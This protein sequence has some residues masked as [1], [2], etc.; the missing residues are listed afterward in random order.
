M[1]AIRNTIVFHSLFYS[2]LNLATVVYMTSFDFLLLTVYFLCVTS[3]LTRVINSFNDEFFIIV[4]QDELK[5]QLEGVKLDDRVD[6]SF[7]FK[8]RY[9]FHTLKEFGI[10]VK[11]KSPDHP[12]YVDWN[13]SSVTD[14]DGKARRVTRLIP[15]NSIDLFQ[16]QALSPVAANNTLKENIVAEDMLKRKGDDGPLEIEKPLLDLS[17]PKKPGDALNRYFE[18]MSLK[19]RLKFSLNLMLRVVNDGTPST[20]YGIPIR[21]DFSLQKLHWYAGLP[22]N[23]KEPD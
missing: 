22:W 12:L 8:G 7:R 21:C 6:I 4:D 2:A 5:K 23:P 13:A 3:V 19:S 10:N 20:G 11:N 1:N 17:K 16:Q 9:E 15:G 18:F 14:L